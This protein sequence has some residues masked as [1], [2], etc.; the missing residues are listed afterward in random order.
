MFLV[1]AHLLGNASHSFDV[2]VARV[3]C[4]SPELTRRLVSQSRLPA[5]MTPKSLCPCG[6]VTNGSWCRA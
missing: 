5:A 6:S 3:H 1:K 4:S 2:E